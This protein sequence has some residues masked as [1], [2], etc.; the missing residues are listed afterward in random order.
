MRRQAKR[1]GGINGFDVGLGKTIEAGMV[2]WPDIRLTPAQAAKLGQG[3][4]VRGP[5]RALGEA[6]SDR[7]LDLLGIDLARDGSPEF[8]YLPDITAGRSWY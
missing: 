5:F 1:F 7:V 8:H 6:L 4:A 2:A 3:Q